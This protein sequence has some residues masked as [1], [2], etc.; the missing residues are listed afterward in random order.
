MFGLT[1][2]QNVA[3]ISFHIYILDTFVIVSRDRFRD[4]WLRAIA[5]NERS[6]ELLTQPAEA[7]LQ[8]LKVECVVEPS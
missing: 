7:V 6:K 3:S 4:S 8:L 1:G 2:L 5:V